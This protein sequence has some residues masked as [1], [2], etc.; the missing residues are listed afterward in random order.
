MAGSIALAMIG[1]LA[2]SCSGPEPVAGLTYRLGP[3]ANQLTLLV[4]ASP[5]AK[6]RAEVAAEDFHSG[7][8]H[9]Y[10]D[11]PAG[12]RDGGRDTVSDE[13]GKEFPVTVALTGPLGS[14][15]VTNEDQDVPQQRSSGRDRNAHFCCAEDEGSGVPKIRYGHVQDQEGNGSQSGARASLGSGRRTLLTNSGCMA[16]IR[17]NVCW[18]V[19]RSTAFAP[20]ERPGARDSLGSSSQKHTGHS[21]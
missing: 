17:R 15:A 4:V 11:E 14:R 21:S 19:T 3:S 16:P 9:V 1:F 10:V 20:P 8:V 2:C 6:V 7:A 12:S 5:S 13:L 18:A